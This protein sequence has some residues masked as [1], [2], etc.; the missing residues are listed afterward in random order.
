LR[1]P[2]GDPPTDEYGYVLNDKGFFLPTDDLWLLAVLNSGHS[3]VCAW[4]G[5]SPRSDG[6]PSC[7]S[8][9]RG[10]LRRPRAASSRCYA[11]AMRAT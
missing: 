10:W 8:A 7:R 1:F 9:M 11:T 3:P 4:S 6:L 5:E 2:L